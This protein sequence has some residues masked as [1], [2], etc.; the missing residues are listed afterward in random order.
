MDLKKYFETATEKFEFTVNLGGWKK[1]KVFN[2]NPKD[3]KS[4]HSDGQVSELSVFGN[5]MNV[6]SITKGGLM[7]YSFDILDNKIT[8]KIKWEDVELGNTLDK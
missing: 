2:F 7:L 8:A 6:H 3:P 1:K 4:K 5:S